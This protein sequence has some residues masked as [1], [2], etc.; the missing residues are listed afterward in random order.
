[1]PK[2]HVKP[3]ISLDTERIF[4]AGGGTANSLRRLLQ[5]HHGS[6]PSVQAMNMWKSRGVIPAAWVAPVLY[7][8][9]R[10]GTRVFDLM[11]RRP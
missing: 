11:V 7:T 2:G 10:E 9:M 4:A 1:M 8:L 5:H 6:A 3:L